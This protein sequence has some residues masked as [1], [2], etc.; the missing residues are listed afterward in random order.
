M[1]LGG[2]ISDLVEAILPTGSVTTDSDGVLRYTLSDTDVRRVRNALLGALPD[3]AQPSGRPLFRLARVDEAVIPA[4]LERYGIYLAVTA[5]TLIGL[6]IW[7][8]RQA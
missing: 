8:G 3:P 2:G 6:G 5:A 1:Q 4:V 7:V